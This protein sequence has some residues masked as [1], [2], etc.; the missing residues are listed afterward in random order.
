MPC[1]PCQRAV[2]L[3][4]VLLGTACAAASLAAQPSPRGAAPSA[5]TVRGV[6]FD[7]V[8]QTPLIGAEVHLARRDEAGTPLRT[9]TDVEGRYRFVGVPSGQYVLGFYHEALD[10]LGLDAPVQGVDLG[11]D[12]VEVMHMSIPSPGVVR[13]LRCGGPANR[14][15]DNALLAGFVRTAVGRQS[16]EGATVT[17]TWSTI[18]TEPGMMRTVPGRATGTVAADGAFS[19]CGIPSDVVLAL[20]VRAAGYRAITGPVTIPEGGTLRQDALLVDTAASTG[21]GEVRGRVLTERDQPVLS[22]RVRIPGLGREV[23]I[24]HGAFAMLDLPVGTWMMEVKAIGVE[25][26]AMFVQASARRNTTLLL[27]IG[28]QA[29]RLDAV[30]IIGRANLVINI[31]DAV[32]ARHRI[33]SGSVF[34]PGSPELRDAQRV[35]DLL[36]TARGFTVLS[37]TNIRA[38]NTATG[39]R[40]EKIGVYVNGVRAIEG[41]EVLD[42]TVRPDQVLAVEAYPDVMSAPFEWRTADGTCA[43]VAMWTRR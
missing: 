7:S 6:L 35:T 34:L 21:P 30:T 33:A 13:M 28:D 37:P 14:A 41:V 12:L 10:L 2:A 1:R 19:M 9:R 25:P 11:G 4:R 42:A 8:A 38:R 32:L 23:P 17:A 16:L 29:Q 3:A 26:R 24:T 43:V 20:E 31:L 5:H 22:G 36:S 39:A 27:R 40:C 15:R 18:S